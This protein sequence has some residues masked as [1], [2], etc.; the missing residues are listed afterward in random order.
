MK[1]FLIF[2]PLSSTAVI[3][4]RLFQAKAL[5]KRICCQKNTVTTYLNNIVLVAHYK[6]G[7][8]VIGRILNIQPT[9][10]DSSEAVFTN[11]IN[12]LVFYMNLILGQLYKS[13]LIQHSLSC[14]WRA[15]LFCF[16]PDSKY[17]SKYLVSWVFKKKHFHN[18][19][20]LILLS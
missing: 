15:L 12:W 7:I 2:F 17:I 5:G 6:F 9:P 11:L 19:N 8:K 13:V 3:T 16:V 1:Q 20:H 10:W 4:L 18:E 14:P